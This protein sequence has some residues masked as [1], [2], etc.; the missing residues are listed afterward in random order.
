M[1]RGYNSMKTTDLNFKISR[2]AEDTNL[3]V[4]HRWEMMRYDGAPIHVELNA[5]ITRHGPDNLSLSLGARYLT[6][7][8]LVRREL[9]NYAI[10]ADFHIAGLNDVASFDDDDA[11]IPVDIMSMMLNVGI[12]ALRGMI[13]LRT[14][15]TIL[16]N[17]P[18]PMFNLRELVSRILSSD[19]NAAGK[20]P[21]IDI[22][23]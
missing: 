8:A 13:A 9:L 6:V 22:P 1:P 18:L 2:I 21:S 17:H 7:R 16:E 3:T 15:G 14:S 5:A 19:K 12:G 4:M 23:N 20:M 11:L 10:T